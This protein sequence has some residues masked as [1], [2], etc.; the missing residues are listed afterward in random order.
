M[1]ARTSASHPQSKQA[2]PWRLLALLMAMTAI[3][4]ATLNI[5]VPALPGLVTRLASD[6]GTVQLTL[7][8]YLLSLA[9]AQLLLGPLSDR[10]GRRP[11]VLSGLALSVVASLAAIAA[12]SIH[13]LI[14]ARVVQ[15]VGASTGIVIG[16]AIIRDL[17]ERER[18]AAMIGLVTTAMV[19]APMISPLIGGI[20]DT[21][22]GWEAI[23]L[24]IAAFSGIVLLWTVLVLPETRPASVAQAP[25]MLI[26]QWRALLGNAKFHGYVLCGALGSAPFFTFLGGGPYVVVTLMG[27]TSAEFGLWFA[28]TSLGYMSGNF[29]ASRLSQ[30]FGIDAMIMAGIAFEL[31]GAGL[32][33][34]LVATMPGAGPA[35]IFLPQMVISYGNGLLLPNAIAGAISIRPHAAGAAS[36]MTGFVQMAVGA[37]STQVVSILLAGAGSAMP[38]AWMLVIVVVATAVAYA[39]LVRR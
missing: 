32:T 31:T 34:L 17:Y 26:E 22:F 5:L 39:G 29:T 37:A 3:G 9:A 25:G 13:A 21:A 15:A 27:R 24:F 35:I 16:R 20:L 30:R 4:P 38:M 18:A 1:D 33:A 28:L 10:F 7:S 19:I 36:G 23:F 11:V 14:G 8:L 6:T 12:Y 2:T